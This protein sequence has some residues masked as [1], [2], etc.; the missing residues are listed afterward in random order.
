MFVSFAIFFNISLC[1]NWPVQVSHTIFP[2]RYL[3]LQIEG[4]LFGRWWRP[5]TRQQ[6]VVGT[7]WCRDGW[8]P[9]IHQNG[10]HPRIYW[11]TIHLG[12][13]RLHFSER[14]LG[15]LDCSNHILLHNTLRSYFH[16]GL[17][18]YFMPSHCPLLKLCPKQPSSFSP[19][20]MAELPMVIAR[21]NL[22]TKCITKVPHYWEKSWF[23]FH[24]QN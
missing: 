6:S 20:S 18:L 12:S 10:L 8:C 14:I 9:T 1:S 5:W 2:L 3:N 19:A 13:S 11:V 17:C 21:S 23:C 15:R 24:C 7:S 4:P 16:G 22:L